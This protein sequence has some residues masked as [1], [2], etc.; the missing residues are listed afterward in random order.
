MDKEYEEKLG[1]PE[2]LIRN[3]TGTVDAEDRYLQASEPPLFMEGELVRVV[4]KP[5][6]SRSTLFQFGDIGRIIKYRGAHY[7]EKQYRAR[8]G[9]EQPEP[10]EGRLTEDEMKKLEEPTQASTETKSDKESSD[11][12]ENQDAMDNDLE[13][14]EAASTETKPDTE[15]EGWTKPW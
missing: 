7:G 9:E 6:K 10:W 3:S 1:E 8:V 15:E 14:T 11:F 2:G 13:E 5:G 4:A 12:L